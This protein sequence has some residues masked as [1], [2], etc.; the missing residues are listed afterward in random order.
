MLLKNRFY[1]LLVTAFLVSVTVNGQDDFGDDEFDLED[2][3]DGPEEPEINIPKAE[4][5]S[6][7]DFLQDNNLLVA[8]A[9]IAITMPMDMCINISS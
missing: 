7:D 4:R 8:E 3:H 6:P 2:E 1:T 9:V 5:V